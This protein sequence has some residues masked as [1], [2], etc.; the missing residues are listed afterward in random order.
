MPLVLKCRQEKCS[1]YSQE[2]TGNPKIDPECQWIQWCNKSRSQ[3]GYYGNNCPVDGKPIYYKTDEP[4]E[5]YFN[6]KPPEECPDCKRCPIEKTRKM[7]KPKKKEQ[8]LCTIKG[9]KGKDNWVGRLITLRELQKQLR[10]IGFENQ[11]LQYLESLRDEVNEEIEM[12][13]KEDHPHV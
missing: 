6:P 10:Y 12:L 4:I 5:Q 9:N 3:P 1:C 13:K 2:L 7:K 11:N 8:P